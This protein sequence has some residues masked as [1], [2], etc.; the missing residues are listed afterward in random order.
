M[1][2]IIEPSVEILT[3]L[4]GMDI[5][6]HL[7]LCARNCYKSEDKITEE[8]APKMVRKL[9]EM[10]HEA[11]IE[12]FSI[13]L[14]LVADT[15]VLK[16]ISRHRLVSFAVE[17]T[18][19]CLYA[20]SKFGNEISVMKPSH[21]REGS[22]EY[23]VWLQCMQDIEKAYLAMAALGCKADAC[24]MVLPHSTKA[25]IIMTANL[26][27]WRHVLKLRTAAAA[28]PTVQEVMKMV[29]K[30]FKEYVPVVFDDIP[31]I[32]LHPTELASE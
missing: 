31:L 14:K 19:Y 9:I 18:R 20:K 27:E 4:N 3:P 10:G 16:D 28:H 24:R 32:E 17:S 21:I 1:V 23:A 22:P 7:E 15:G 26:R 29:L 6:K 13:S 5:L 30:S 8:S 2:K 11:M 25:E 12:H